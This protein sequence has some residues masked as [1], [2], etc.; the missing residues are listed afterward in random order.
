MKANLNSFFTIHFS[1]Q[2]KTVILMESGLGTFCPG[3]IRS[4]R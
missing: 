3:L 4:S 2:I 1:F